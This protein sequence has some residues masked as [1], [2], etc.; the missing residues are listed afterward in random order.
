MGI[1]AQT[2]VPKFTSGDVLTAA[3][4][5]L[6]TNA[7]PVFSG[8][9][10]RDA[11]F[12]GA[13][14]KTLAEGQ[15]CYLED[16]N[17]VQYYDGA[18]WATVGPATAGA[19][20]LVKSQTIGTGV[21]TVAVSDAFNATYDAYKIIVSGGVASGNIA[22]SLVLGASTTTYYTA[23]LN[24]N[25]SS[26]VISA[27]STSNGSAFTYVGYATTD[28]IAVDIDILNP[29]LAK[30]TLFGT[31]L[32]PFTSSEGGFATGEHRTSTSYS[33]FTL[34]VGGSNMTGGKIN[35][36]GYSLS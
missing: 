16:S 9:A 1:N 15:L 33:A 6:L 22:V 29:F 4:A 8:T 18:A 3:N 35:V 24:I 11:S 13:G 7:P 12:G 23:Q 31:A 32:L 28:R 10:T 14:E 2:S 26:N 34:G 25:Y 5:D 17:I 21:S 19:L 27:A 30:P 20:V 36:Y